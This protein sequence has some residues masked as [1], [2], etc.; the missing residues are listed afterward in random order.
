MKFKSII[1]CLA[2]LVAT[3]S[4]SLGNA[5]GVIK[6]G[7]IGPLTGGSSIA[8]LDE[9]DA[10]VLAVEEING[11]GGILGKKVELY[12]EDDASQPSQSAT[13]AMKL[14]NQEDV[15]AILG[16]H[17]SPCT[18]AVMQIIARTG[19][20]LITSG[21][22]SP[23][24]TQG[25]NEWIT[26][27]SPPDSVQ[28]TALIQYA[29]FNGFKNI[30]IIYLND[31]YGKG[32]LLAVEATMKN[33]DK[34]LAGA[35][36][37]MSGDKDM[38]AQLTKLKKQGVDA[39]LIWTNYVDGSLV[40]R[41]ARE[42]G[43]NVQ[44]FT[45]TGVVHNRTFELVGPAYEGTIHSVPYTQNSPE[46]NVQDFVKAFEKRFGRSPS[47]PAARAYDSA[48]ILFAA[49]EK[50]GSLEKRDIQK[51]IRNIKNFKGLQ[52]DISINPENGE[53]EGGVM[54]VKANYE[55]RDFD[56]I[57]NFVPRK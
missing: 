17:N 3:F 25:G 46:K 35:E 53:Y 52:G 47:Q 15:V 38:R 43:W 37:F 40:M 21:S 45:G 4:A 54:I 1:V 49:I 55:K 50:A 22:T 14:I 32:G 2:M 41:Q 20:S 51:E 10:K 57:E 39:L 23:K 42:M 7:A 12:S 33:L 8:G 18:L 24:V 36:S 28:A 5:Q 27:V 29:F 19:V 9:R 34:K 6:I 26:R 48:K 44:F 16:A 30:G 31:D 56:F 13:V 11:K